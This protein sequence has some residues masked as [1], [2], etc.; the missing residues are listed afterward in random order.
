MKPH[1]ALDCILECYH[2]VTSL[3]YFQILHPLIPFSPDWVMPVI[4]QRSEAV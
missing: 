2:P 1:V 4:C 3:F